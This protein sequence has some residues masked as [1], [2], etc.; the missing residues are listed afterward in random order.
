MAGRCGRRRHRGG[1]RHVGQQTS[2]GPRR[3]HGVTG[4]NRSDR[5]QELF[6]L[7]VLEQ[8]P[9]GTS[10][11]CGQQVLVGVERREYQDFRDTLLP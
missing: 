2:G 1:S 5:G 9:A 11:D 3:D 8:E 4:M 7:R 10:G 6:R